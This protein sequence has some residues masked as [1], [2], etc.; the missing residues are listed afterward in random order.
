[1]HK[2]WKSCLC[3]NVGTVKTGHRLNEINFALLSAKTFCKETQ[4][5]SKT[6][7]YSPPAR[8]KG[9]SPVRVLQ[10][11]SDQKQ[12]RP[13]SSSSGS[14]TEK[15]GSTNPIENPNHDC[16]TKQVNTTNAA[17]KTG[18]L[19]HQQDVTPSGRLLKPEWQPFY[20]KGGPQ[21]KKTQKEKFTE[22]NKTGKVCTNLK[23]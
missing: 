12:S 2:C 7:S 13:T 8:Q 23:R 3:T 10:R 9:V 17:N 1:M 4:S 5:R 21:Q 22:P 15:P 18:Q 14:A 11:Q 16:K 20:K 19:L 6:D